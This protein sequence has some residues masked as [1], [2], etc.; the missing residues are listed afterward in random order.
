MSRANRSICM[1]TVSRDDFRFG[2]FHTTRLWH[3]KYSGLCI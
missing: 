2:N 3:F 1:S